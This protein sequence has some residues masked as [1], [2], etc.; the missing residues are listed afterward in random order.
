M[1]GD[2]LMTPKWTAQ[3]NDT[4]GGFIVT[5]Y[6]YPLSEHNHRPD[7]DPYADPTKRSYIIAEFAL[8]KDA[9]LIAKLLNEHEQVGGP[10]Q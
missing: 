2:D 10:V 1:D 7:G 4:V 8:Q 5:D 6:P 3:V 9:E